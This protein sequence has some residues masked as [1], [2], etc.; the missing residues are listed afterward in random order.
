MVRS[1]TE[2]CLIFQGQA[3]KSRLVGAIPALAAG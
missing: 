3:L 1:K 2:A